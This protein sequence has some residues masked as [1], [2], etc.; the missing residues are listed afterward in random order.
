[1]RRRSITLRSRKASRAA[2][3]AAVALAG[4]LAAV[5][6]PGAATAAETAPT[7][8][9]LTAAPAAD[10]VRPISGS[11]IVRL[12][13]GADA[14]GLA[15]TLSVSPRY[16]YDTAVDGFAADLTAGQLRTLQRQKSVV[17]IEQ[18]SYVDN[19]KDATQTNPPSWGIDRV[20]QR[21]LPLS[22]SYTY[23]ATGA[24]VH[25]YVIDTGID[26]THPD[27]GGRAQFVAGTPN[28]LVYT[29]GL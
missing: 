11:Y 12:T 19:A 25:A 6:L 5:G 17:A 9:P 21:N 28:L 27:F 16:V 23:T 4:T 29:G 20:D 18:D 15:R 7:A 13:P 24:G 1:M 2:A 8:V 10:G 26:V 14:R 3:L 22:A